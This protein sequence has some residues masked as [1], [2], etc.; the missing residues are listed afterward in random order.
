MLLNVFLQF[1]PGTPTEAFVHIWYIE[2]GER[3]LHLEMVDGNCPLE[4]SFEL[5]L[6][7]LRL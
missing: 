3:K 6:L 2:S 4:E 7:N 5:S 1:E